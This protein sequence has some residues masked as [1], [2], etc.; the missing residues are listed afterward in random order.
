MA[1]RPKAQTSAVAAAI[2]QPIAVMPKPSAATPYSSR[3]DQLRPMADNNGD[4]EDPGDS[5]TTPSI[6]FRAPS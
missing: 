4:G 5:M 1:I 6:R 2:G 3:I